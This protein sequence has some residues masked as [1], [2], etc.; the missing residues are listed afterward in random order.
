[1]VDG[2][3]G[4][5]LNRD[6]FETFSGLRV[7]QQTRGAKKHP[8]S[9]ICCAC[10]SALGWYEKYQRPH[11]LRIDVYEAYLKRYGTVHF[12]EPQIKR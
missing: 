5:A 1:M 7:G 12:T 4:N 2:R 8:R 11:G 10:N 9:V 6:H 3:A